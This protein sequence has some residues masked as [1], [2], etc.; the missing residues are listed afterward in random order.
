M[1]S[2]VLF[3]VL[4]WGLGHATRSIPV[5]DRL[6]Q[7]DFDVYIA[8]DGEALDLLQR[9]YPSLNFFALPSYNVKYPYQSVFFNILRYSGNIV[10]AVIQE[11]REAKRLSEKINADVIISDSR[12]GFRYS[13]SYNI[14]ISHQ[15]SLQLSNALLSIAGTYVNKQMIKKFD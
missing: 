12:F 13:G 9:H 15:I 4:N 1:Q 11:G 7:E 3:G 8:S 5:I 10:N 2:K 6:L 14:F